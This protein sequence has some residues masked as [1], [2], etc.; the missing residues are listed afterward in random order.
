MTVSVAYLRGTGY[1]KAGLENLGAEVHHLGLRFYGDLK[2]LLRLRRLIKGTHIDLI[3]AHLPPAELYARLALLGTSRSAL[4]LLI[5]KHNEERFCNAPGHRALGRWVARRAD[6]VIAISDAVKRYMA[7]SGLGI[8]ADKIQTIYYGIDAT[9]FAVSGGKPPNS[10]LTIGFVGRL[11]PQ[12][13]IATL[14]R[15]FALFVDG[16]AK[17]RLVIV[18]EGS[19]M[20]ELRQLADELG[21]ASHVEWAGFRED[22]A[23]VM[24]GFDI[25]ALTSLYEGLGLV[26]LEAMA[27]GVAVAATRVG[28]IPEVVVDGETGLLVGPGQPQEL[29][30]AF[31]KLSDSAL[32]TRMGEAGRRRVIGR[33]TL[34]RMWRETD[35]LYARQTEAS[36][37]MLVFIVPIKSAK[38]SR[39]WSLSSRLFERCLRSICQQTSQNFRVVVVC[40]ERPEIQ[41][42]HPNVHYIEVDFPPPVPVPDEE[43]TAGYEYGF[44]RDIARKN[45]DKARK[46][47]TGLDYAARYHPTHSMVV[48]ADDCVSSR[49]AEFVARNPRSDGWFFKKGYMYPEGGR[50]LYFNVRNFYQI[51]GSSVIIAYGLT[52]ALF[53]NPDFYEHTFDAP[54]P[55][56][57]LTPLPFA[58]AVYSM[59]NG[60]NIY[61]S[62]ETRQSIHGTLL[63]R[64]F[65]RDVFALARK[66]LKYRPALLTAAIR[67]E[68]GTY[69]IGDQ[70][71]PE[72]PVNALNASAEPQP[73]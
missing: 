8:P 3:H 36:S 41:F 71:S 69:H 32:R 61:M 30:A 14:L 15:G 63:K 17:A 33:F 62:S 66:V 58:G 60:D 49:L 44:S 68:F 13:D 22:I 16:S 4:P 1:W 35:D 25:F 11:V 72:N 24:G 65:S 55:G 26:L 51:C 54:P 52:Q 40:N 57:A 5:S 73:Q 70:P 45:A 6:R 50:F 10:E 18:G 48:D 23:A 7:G 59:E 34:E 21:I 42:S 12:K 39:S 47:H 29:A 9:P 56:A 28:A 67:K 2:P 37:S 53:G 31:Q 46:I 19:L 64:I 20:G 43:R 27:A 38:L